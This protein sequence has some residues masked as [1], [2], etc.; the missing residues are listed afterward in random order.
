MT[1]IAYPQYDS[2]E[3]GYKLKQDGKLNITFP[4]VNY[5]S[6]DVRQLFIAGIA[7]ALLGIAQNESNYFSKDIDYNSRKNPPA[8][9]YLLPGLPGYQEGGSCST[10]FSVGPGMLQTS[11]TE[12]T[13]KTNGAVLAQNL[14]ASFELEET[15]SSSPFTCS[16]ASTILSGLA[17]IASVLPGF[18]WLAPISTVMS[19]G[20]KG[21]VARAGLSL[22]CD[23]NSHI[24]G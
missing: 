20:K 3:E 17:G 2:Y 1:G 14:A 12:Q 5:Y 11:F 4:F 18:E 15:P 13:D 8:G 7:H 6:D 9:C 21:S 10:L 19:L 16:D 22:G 23:L 24:N